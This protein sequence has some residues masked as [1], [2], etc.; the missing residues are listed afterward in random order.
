[1][2]TVLGHF[3]SFGCWPWKYLCSSSVLNSENIRTL[4]SAGQQTLMLA[5][6]FWK[7][8]TLLVLLETTFVAGGVLE[9]QI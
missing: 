9:A 1:M 7:H 5:I 8:L 6:I 4:S 3:L 2:K